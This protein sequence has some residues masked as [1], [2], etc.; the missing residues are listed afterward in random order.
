LADWVP[1][2]IIAARCRCSKARGGNEEERD[3]EGWDESHLDE[4]VV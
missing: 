3:E 4:D 2:T 1:E